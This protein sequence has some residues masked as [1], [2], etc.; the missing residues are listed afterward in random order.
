[1]KQDQQSALAREEYTRALGIAGTQRER[2]PPAAL[3][4][5]AADV[6]TLL[7]S[8]LASAPAGARPEPSAQAF[9]EFVQALVFGSG[10][11]AADIVDAARAGGAS[12][13]TVYLAYLSRAA[14]HLGELWD[15]DRI[16]FLQVTVAVGRI[17][18]I[19]RGL[20]QTL[21][22][23]PEDPLRHALF[24]TMPGD[25]HV[26]GA[27]I[28]TDMFRSRGWDIQLEMPA[29]QAQAE[30]ALQHSDHTV[31]GIAA[32]RGDQLGELARLVVALRICRPAT[33]VLISGPIAEAEPDLLDVVDAD[34]LASTAHAAIDRLEEL[35]ANRR[36]SGVLR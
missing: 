18:A 15:Q 19:M 31:V 7:S 25:D 8:R 16:G 23:G 28:A 3:Q 13:D 33:F 21:R 9:D 10:H 1:V 4:A 22:G 11:E 27:T 5:L 29:D 14:R 35:I 12:L 32:S 24:I 20:R 36:R 34:A 30:E 26:L 2:L 6:V 17:Y